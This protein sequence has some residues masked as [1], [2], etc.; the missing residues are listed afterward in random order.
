VLALLRRAID[1]LPEAERAHVLGDTAARTYGLH[2]P[3]R[4][5]SG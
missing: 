1:D 5:E 2:I 3:G 4:M